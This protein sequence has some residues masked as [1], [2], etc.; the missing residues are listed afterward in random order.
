M[1]LLP[2]HDPFCNFLLQLLE[3]RNFGLAPYHWQPQILLTASHNLHSHQILNLLLHLR[4]YILAKEKGCLLAIYG[5]S[6]GSLVL[7]QDIKQVMTFTWSGFI[8]K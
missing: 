7:G 8:K 2:A 5:L 4:S 1:L 6:R 3:H